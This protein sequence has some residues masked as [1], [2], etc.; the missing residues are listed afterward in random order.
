MWDKEVWG[1]H[2]PIIDES[3]FNQVQNI[4]AERKITQDRRQ[5]RD[6]LRGLVYCLSFKRRLTAEVHQR[7]N[8]IGV[9]AASTTIVKSHIFQ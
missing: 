2:K 4:L 9:R 7:E 3:L 8:I 5:K 6:F 1:K